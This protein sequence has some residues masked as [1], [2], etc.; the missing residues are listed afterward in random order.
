MSNVTVKKTGTPT[1]SAIED[2][3]GICYEISVGVITTRI[4]PDFFE[5]LV[6]HPK[7]KRCVLNTTGDK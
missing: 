2:E 3:Q 5:T 4:S 7:L 6:N 1:M